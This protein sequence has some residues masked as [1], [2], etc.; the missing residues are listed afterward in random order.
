MTN[1]PPDRRHRTGR[2]FGAALLACTLASPAVAETRLPDIGNPVDQVLSP[3]D[4]ALI[5]RDMFAQARQ[6]MELNEDPQIAGYIDRLGN[7]LAN[8]IG[9]DPVNGYTFFVVHDS[10]INA[11]AAPGGYIGINS[12]LFLAADNESQLAGVLAHEIAH[13]TQRHIAKAYAASQR[14]QYTTLAAV[15]AGLV[16]EVYLSD[17]GSFDPQTDDAEIT[18]TYSATGAVEQIDYRGGTTITNGYDLRDRLTK[19]NNINST[20]GSP[21]AARYYYMQ[22]SNVD[23]A[24]F[25]NPNIDISQNLSVDDRNYSYDYNYDELNRL[26][27]ANYYLDATDNPTSFDVPNIDYDP[28]GNIE[29]L[30]RRDQAGTLVDDLDYKYENGNNQLSSLDETASSPHPWDPKAGSF[31]YDD[32]GNLLTMTGNTTLSGVTYDH[33]N[34]PTQFDL[35]A[36][37][38]QV[39]GYSMEGQRVLKEVQTSSGT[40]WN[41]YIMDGLT[42]LGLIQDG[43]LQYMNI[44]GN[45]VTGRAVDDRLAGDAT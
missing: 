6:R 2:A 25:W 22:N 21:F 13:V 45:E 34:L 17:N 23:S 29:A 7:S 30:Q 15:L 5:G 40:T 39:N 16:E 28:A 19:I 20:S 38:Q 32:N 12:G 37:T 27:G 11:F 24:R 44:L 43:T 1:P 4:E 31:T 9:G 33:R 14:N 41:F 10:R 3:Q 8:E 42:T 35:S 18:Y 26:T 36:S